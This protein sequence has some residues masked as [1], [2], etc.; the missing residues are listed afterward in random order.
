MKRIYI[1][2]ILYSAT[3]MNPEVA[4][5]PLIDFYRLKQQYIWLNS[6][7][8]Y[9]I[10]EAIQKYPNIT[11]DD[12]CSIIQYESGNYCNNNL[13]CMKK[14]RSYA[15]AIGIMQIMP[16]HCKGL[17]QDLYDPKINIMY[18]ARYYNWCLQYAKGNKSQAL[19]YYNAGPFSSASTYKGW[20]KYVL[21]IMKSSEQSAVL[22]NEY[23]II[24]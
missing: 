13:E 8:Y 3:L 12:L 18:G 4:F 15:G 5:D 7:I 24:R 16:F 6:Q 23:A 19:R 20:K 11:Q 22:F 21:A 17:K 2:I 14:V 10:Y 1:T 9:F